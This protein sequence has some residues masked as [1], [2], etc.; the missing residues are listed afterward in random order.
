MGLKQFAWWQWLSFRSKQLS[1]TNG[2]RFTVDFPW[3]TVL[4]TVQASEM[5]ACVLEPS[6]PIQRCLAGEVRMMMEPCWLVFTR[7]V[8]NVLYRLEMEMQQNQ[9]NILVSLEY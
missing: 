3:R 7:G 8:A 1:A 2:E 5:H 9:C 4:E 6:P